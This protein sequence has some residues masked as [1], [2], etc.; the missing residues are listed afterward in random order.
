MNTFSNTHLLLI[1]RLLTFLC[2][3]IVFTCN[4]IFSVKCYTAVNLAV[5]KV[6]R[7]GHNFTVNCWGKDWKKQDITF[8]EQRYPDDVMNR[9]TWIAYMQCK[10]HNKFFNY[11]SLVSFRVY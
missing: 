11:T 1:T 3:S 9:L 4:Y 2:L 6:Q 10:K 7:N 8:T 5:N